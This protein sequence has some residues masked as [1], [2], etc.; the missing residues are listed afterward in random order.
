MSPPN[1]RMQRARSSPSALRSPLMRCPLSP[2]TPVGARHASAPVVAILVI[3]C[4]GCQHANPPPYHPD[5]TLREDLSALP[6][7][8]V[9]DVALEPQGCGAGSARVPERLWPRLF[10]VLKTLTPAPYYSESEYECLGRIEISGP[11][12]DPKAGGYA[13]PILVCTLTLRLHAPTGRCVVEVTSW[14]AHSSFPYTGDAVL[15]WYN[16]ALREGA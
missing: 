8:R 2:L 15:E 9:V 7:Q 6:R 3:L 13:G 14:N 10:T 16:S 1:A 11:Q 12:P 5:G 4:L